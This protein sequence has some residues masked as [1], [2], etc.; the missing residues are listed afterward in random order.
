MKDK[1]FDR[2]LTDS[3][4]QYGSE[5]YHGADGP[6]DTGNAPVHRF[7][8]DFLD[9]IT[10]SHKPKKPVI[11]K[12]LPFIGA[13]AA[14]AVIG[15]S[16][17]SIV[18]KLMRS[19]EHGTPGSAWVAD[20]DKQQNGSY[21]QSYNTADSVSDGSDTNRSDI[22]KIETAQSGKNT[23]NE[24]SRNE[25]IAFEQEEDYD[26]HSG[27]SSYSASSIPSPSP[28]YDNTVLTNDAHYTV[29][30]NNIILTPA[31]SDLN[32]LSSCIG[33]IMTDNYIW[34]SSSPISQAAGIAEI[35]ISPLSG[36]L[37]VNGVSYDSIT[38]TL[39]RDEVFIKAVSGSTAE[40]YEC[41]FSDANYTALKNALS[42]LA[43]R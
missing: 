1:D 27:K 16:A 2:L 14:A 18:P 7:R 3:I 9:D 15:L 5:Y 36:K 39:N 21:T 26:I 32:L 40:Y 11:I 31:K 33:S 19:S 6:I 43:D 34:Y 37:T 25:E 41:D 13:A 42:T 35:D 17:V 12:L 23:N 24:T 38:V 30:Y 22:S 28:A 8:E 10:I 4:K 29:K 20:D